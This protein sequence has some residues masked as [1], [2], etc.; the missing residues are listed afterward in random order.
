LDEIKAKIKGERGEYDGTLLL[1]AKS[2]MKLLLLLLLPLL[3]QL[4]YN[5][6]VVDRSA[7]V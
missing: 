4:T 7:M 2:E 5:S 1:N 3:L 6:D